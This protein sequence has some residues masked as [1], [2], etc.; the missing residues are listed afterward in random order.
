MRTTSLFLFAVC[1]VA[2]ADLP[3]IGK[4][5]LNPAKSDFTGTTI[6]Y[7]QRGTEIEY[8]EQG[9]SYKFQIDGKDYATPFGYTAAWKKQGDNSWEM[10]AKLTGKPI[11]TDTIKLSADGKTLTVVSKG[12]RPDGE[13]WE[14]STTYQRVSGAKGLDGK[15]KATQVKIG[16][17]KLIEFAAYGDGLTWRIADYGVT[18]TAKFDGKDYPATGPTAPHGFTVAISKTSPGSFDLT[19]KIEGKAVYKATYSVSVDGKTLTE[20]GSSTAVDE[21]TT[22][23]YDRQ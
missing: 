5:K 1:T 21:K 2:A 14:D 6:T 15:W 17:L 18:C 3:Y 8:T 20:V 9:Q 13:P 11:E 4:W 10:V 16:S 12:T 19:E 23:V 22:S 7:A